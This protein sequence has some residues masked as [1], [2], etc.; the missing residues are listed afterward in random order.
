MLSYDQN[1][2]KISKSHLIRL[3][4]LNHPVHVI[5]FGLDRSDHIKRT[6]HFTVYRNSQISRSI[7]TSSASNCANLCVIDKDEKLCSE[8]FI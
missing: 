4:T 2:I 6:Y 7:D 1:V 3:S 5:A 8:L